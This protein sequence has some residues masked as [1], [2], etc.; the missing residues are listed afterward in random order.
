MGPVWVDLRAWASL[1]V[2]AHLAVLAAIVRVLGSWP[3]VAG[4]TLGP[5]LADLSP[6]YLGLPPLALLALGGRLRWLAPLLAGGAILLAEEPLALRRQVLLGAALCL[7]VAVGDGL[8]RRFG[9]VERVPASRPLLAR[10]LAAAVLWAL[11]ATGLAG[12]AGRKRLEAPT[13]PF[14]VRGRANLVLITLD[15]FRPEALEAFGS[16]REGTPHLDAFT[17]EGTRIGHAVAAAPHTHPSMATILT[18]LVPWAHGSVAGRPHLGASHSTLAEHL[19]RCGYRTAGFFE[20]PW[21]TREFGFD[22]GFETFVGGVSGR[23]PARAAVE[24]LE[25][26]AAGADGSAGRFYCHIHLFGAHGPYEPRSPWIE[27]WSPGYDG[28]YRRISNE[29]LQAAEL[30]GAVAFTQEDRQRIVALYASEAAAVDAEVGRVLACLDRLEIDGD[31]LVVITADHGEELFDHGGLHH[32]HTLHAELLNA[33]LVLR[34]PGQLK[35]NHIVRGPIGLVDL[36]P[37]LLDL[38]GL[39][40]FAPQPGSGSTRLPWITGHEEW[41]TLPPVTSTRFLLRGQHL[42]AH[43]RYPWK[44]IV[45]WPVDPGAPWR[46]FD[47]DRDRGLEAQLFHL[48]N[49]STEQNDL[50]DEEPDVLAQMIDEWRGSQVQQ[51]W[52]T[53]EELS[54]SPEQL[55]ALRGMGYADVL[56]EWRAGQGR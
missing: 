14:D 25:E 8:L 22:Q 26:A 48:P 23:D 19:R 50:A 56:E 24:W 54:V 16:T 4:R 3:S 37:T 28:P 2:L 13:E 43:L 53:D 45:R 41:S 34:W 10:G 47:P 51:A 44:L 18:G 46:P 27:R 39:P 5:W 36:A 9:G 29:Q 31:T 11:V 49:D 35:P 33:P 12:L 1:R 30:P 55:E 32:G 20:N 38:L 42:A 7:Y 17:R 15:T 52:I 6:V 21:M 40:A